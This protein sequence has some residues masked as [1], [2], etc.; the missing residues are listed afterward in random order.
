MSAYLTRAKLLLA[1]HRPVD[2][3]REARTGLEQNPQNRELLHVL[4]SAL[5]DQEKIPAAREVVQ[6]LI[7]VAPSW[8]DAH[9]MLCYIELESKHYKKAEL[10][11]L[12][13][14]RLAPDSAIAHQNLA[15]CYLRQQRWAEALEKAEAGLA[16][17][18]EN[19][20][21]ANVRAIALSHLGRKLESTHS[22]DNALRRN[23]QSSQTQATAGFVQ[24]A[25]GDHKRAL[26]H[27]A[28]ALR[29]DPENDV[30]RNGLV[31]SLKARN[32]IYRALLGYSFW[33]R[34]LPPGRR[35]GVT[36]GA[37]FIYNALGSMQNLGVWAAVITIVYLSF[38]MLTW[39]GSDFFNFVLLLD[40]AARHAL[41]RRQRYGAVALLLCLS[42]AL[43]WFIAGVAWQKTDLFGTFPIIFYCI[44]LTRAFRKGSDWKAITRISVAVLLG[45]SLVSCLAYLQL[46]GSEGPVS[47]VF[48][49]TV[50][51]T[52]LVRLL[53]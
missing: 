38:V 22:A 17:D 14:L 40:K 21:C 52:W 12:D 45:V 28:E 50:L 3:E 24:L 20:G 30:A 4:A 36:L 42:S 2:A 19:T 26:E 13:A 34:R 39:V 51:Y 31:E 18:A 29:L 41:D 11:A 43:G 35:W 53:D 7:G 8:A 16:L 49:L 10:A 44:P 9:L 1:T 48:M 46:S 32:P 15:V 47:M 23:P 5:A 37:L 25:G 27:F 6:E 33:M